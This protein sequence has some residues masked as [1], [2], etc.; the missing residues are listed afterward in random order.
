MKTIKANGIEAEEMYTATITFRS[1]GD[2]IQVLPES[3]YSHQF[4]DDYEGE[5]PSSF[6]CVRDINLSLAKMTQLHGMDDEPEDIDDL[7]EDEESISVEDKQQALEAFAEAVQ[8]KLKL[9]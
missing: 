5:Y 2:S 3:S 8:G 7:F 1:V 6:L 9:H 4:P